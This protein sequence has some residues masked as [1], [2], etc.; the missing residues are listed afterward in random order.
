MR[1]F[2]VITDAIQTANPRLKGSWRDRFRVQIGDELDQI[3]MDLA[4]GKAWIPTLPDGS[5][6]APVIPSS[7]VRLRAATTLKEMLDGKAVAQTELLKAEQEAKDLES[8]RALSDTELEAQAAKILEERRRPALNPGPVTDAE[9]V[10]E[11]D[12]VDIT[13]YGEQIWAAPYPHLDPED[14]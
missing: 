7:D 14:E 9:V 3:L 8:I 6:S 2:T 13:Q 1:A 12:P 4:R 10:T 5:I 11:G